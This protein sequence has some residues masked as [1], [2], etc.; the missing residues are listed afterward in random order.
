MALAVDPLGG[1]R[2]LDAEAVHASDEERGFFHPVAQALGADQLHGLHQG[3][4]GIAQ[5][6][7]VDRVMDIGL[8]AGGIQEARIQVYRFHQAQVFGLVMSATDQLIHDL[9]ERGAVAPMGLALECAFAR[10][11]DAVD[12]KKNGA[13][14]VPTTYPLKIQAIRSKG[15]QPRLYLS[16]PL[17]LATAIG[18]EPGEEVQWELLDRS[19]LH[20]VRPAVEPPTTS[21]RAAKK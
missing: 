9:I 8:K 10:H 18:L 2:H 14:R 11:D 16:F 17:A 12:L 5:Q 6:H 21:R 3:A 7:P 4:R 13:L 19:E 20:L 15:Q 1:M